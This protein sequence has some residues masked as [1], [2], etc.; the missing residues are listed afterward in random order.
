MRTVIISVLFLFLAG[1]IFFL[2]WALEWEEVGTMLT[3][4]LL[5]AAAVAVSLFACE[6]P[7]CQSKIH[8]PLRHVSNFFLICLA[9][10]GISVLAYEFGLS[11]RAQLSLGIFAAAFGHIMETL[12][13]FAGIKGSQK[14]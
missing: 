4:S 12:G 13:Y 11:G 8:H 14:Q 6:Q 10:A 1:A 3:L 9:V 7:W 2:L 5:L